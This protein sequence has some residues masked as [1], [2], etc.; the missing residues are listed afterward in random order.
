MLWN[1]Y[2]I[3]AAYT[4]DFERERHHEYVFVDAHAADVMWTT[5]NDKKMEDELHRGKTK[6]A[7][8]AIVDRKILSGYLAMRALDLDTVLKLA[9]DATSQFEQDMPHLERR[10]FRGEIQATPQG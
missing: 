8:A 1:Y 5:W 2:L 3:E 4:D 10:N 9:R 6:D 7:V